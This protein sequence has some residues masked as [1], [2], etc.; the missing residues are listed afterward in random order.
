MN[1]NNSDSASLD[2]ANILQKID[3]LSK[4]LEEIEQSVKEISKIKIILSENNK[5]IVGCSGDTLIE[6]PITIMEP[7]FKSSNNIIHDIPIIFNDENLTFVNIFEGVIA[8]S[9][10][11]V[12]LVVL[13]LK[14]NTKLKNLLNK[15]SL[16]LD[17]NKIKYV[18]DI[19]DFLSMTKNCNQ[20]SPIKNII[21]EVKNIL[22]NNKLNLHDVPLLVNIIASALNSNLQDLQIKTKLDVFLICLIIKLLIHILIDLQILCV[23][24]IEFINI[25][26]AINSSISLL[27]TVIHIPRPHRK[28]SLFCCGKN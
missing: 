28:Y 18:K 10:D 27:S 13:F 1:P 17:N 23:N 24:E 5:E 20:I 15:L 12:T 26:K 7:R 25:N 6:S 11:E 8:T 19:F 9:F 21:F 4:N 16:Q 2:K 3:E 22:E 14:D